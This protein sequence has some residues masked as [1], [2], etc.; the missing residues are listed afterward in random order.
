MFF[1]VK[2]LAS[3]FEKLSFLKL[4]YTFFHIFIRKKPFFEYLKGFE[5]LFVGNKS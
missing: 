5:V 3:F 2:K 4:L 1:F